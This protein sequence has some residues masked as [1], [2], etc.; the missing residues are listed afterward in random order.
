M[1]FIFIFYLTNFSDIWF[2]SLKDMVYLDVEISDLNVPHSG[3]LNT[4]IDK[5]KKSTNVFDLE[6]MVTRNRQIDEETF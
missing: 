3:N 5:L 4:E 6:I 2:G 1:I